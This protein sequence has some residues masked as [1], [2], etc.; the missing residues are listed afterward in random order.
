ML[1]E[2]AATIG[3]LSA[4]GSASNGGDGTLVFTCSAAT[5]PTESEWNTFSDWTY[6]E[7]APGT[8]GDDPGVGPSWSAWV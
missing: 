5:A 8:G 3:A 4:S 2:T 7:S 1:A 6:E